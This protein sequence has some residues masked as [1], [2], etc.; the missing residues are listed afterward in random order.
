MITDEASRFFPVEGQDK[1]IKMKRRNP[2]LSE[3]NAM[4]RPWL[5]GE[6]SH[7]EARSLD[8]F[9]NNGCSLKLTKG[10]AV[11]TNAV[12]RTSDRDDR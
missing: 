2:E 5:T 6:S 1:I 12:D 10:W 8:S 4:E 11:A 3:Y 9:R 7:S